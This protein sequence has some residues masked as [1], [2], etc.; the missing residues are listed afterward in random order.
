MLLVSTAAG[1][2]FQHFMGEGAASGTQLDI[3]QLAQ[4][5]QN[6]HVGRATVL[7]RREESAQT[8]GG[9]INTLFEYSMFT[10]ILK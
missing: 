5:G 4:I 9:I 10:S 8:I 1:P 7:V 6:P 2:V 3:N